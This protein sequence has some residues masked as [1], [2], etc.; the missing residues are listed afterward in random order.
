[1]S[2]STADPLSETLDALGYQGAEGLVEGSLPEAASARAFVWRELREKGELDAAYFRGSVPLVGFVR[3][4]EP[5]QVSRVQ[6]R[7]WNLSRVPLLIATTADQVGAYSCFVP[8]SPA[9]DAADARLGLARTTD[10]VSTALAEFSRFNVETG[11]LTA[12][13]PSKFLRRNRVDQRLLENLRLLREELGASHAKQ[14][15]IDTMIGRA[16]FIR[17]F[18][19]RGILSP[20]HLLE[21]TPF[22]TFIEVLRDGTEAAY[23]LF[24]ALADRFDGDVFAHSSD[25]KKL[26]SKKDLGILADFFSG[27]DMPTRQQALWPYDF[28]IIPPELISSIYEQLL[29]EDQVKD[30]AYYTPRHVV[31][32]ILDEVLPWEATNSQPRI[33]DPACG[34][35][36]FLT[37]AYRR[38]NFRNS[39]KG[40]PRFSDLVETL[41]TCIHGID[42]NPAAINVAAFG[43]YLALF[44]ELDPPSAWREAKLPKLIGR[45]LLV[46]DFFEP[47]ALDKTDF[48]VVVGNPPWQ[49]HLSPLAEEFITY[50]NV[51]LADKQIALAFLWKASRVVHDDGVLGLLL[52]AKQLLHNKAPRAIEVRRAIFESLHVDTVIDLSSLRRQT[53]TA[54][55]APAAVLVARRTNQGPHDVLHVV[56]RSSPLQLAVDGFVVSQDDIHRVPSELAVNYPDVWKIYLW[57][58]HHDLQIITRL[59]S[60]YRTLADIAKERGWIHS[61]GFEPTGPSRNDATH[62][63]GMPFIATEAVLPF[64]ITSI[65]EVVE[66]AI[67]HRPRNPL[68]FKGPH[69]LIRRGLYLGKPAAALVKQDAAFN[70]GVFGIAAPKKD[71]NYLRLLTAYINSSLGSYYQFMTSGSWG[72]ERDF[73]E[74]NEH[75]ALPFAELSD[76]Q[77]GPILDLLSIIEKRGLSQ[78]LQRKLDL[79]IYRAYGLTE[80]EIA[81]INDR[82]ATSLDQFQKRAKSVAFLPPPRAALMAY[83]RELQKRLTNALTSLKV[84]VE[85]TPGTWA[86]A[87]ASVRLTD[88]SADVSRITIESQPDV[89]EALLRQVNADVQNWPSPVTIVQPS[90]VVMAG[91]Q[92]HLVKPNEL[93]YWTVSAAEADSGDI[94]GAIAVQQPAAS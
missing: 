31:D 10:E 74:E 6:R 63:V 45:N 55:I 4:T 7:L 27:T 40:K 91:D 50:Q 39:F 20:D 66:Q 89:I 8:P 23:D 41:T 24:D 92:I 22:E 75:L 47:H 25:E 32:L 34:S 26:I 19:D 85:L 88:P 28:S 83:R 67:M 94:L 81:L 86:Y 72:V 3:A 5:E 37:E 18:E 29:E 43:L 56:P 59:R 87:V 42:R 15:A 70:N 48:D 65:D 9:G 71:I 90:A 38:L 53:F 69:V 78:D 12:A 54:A 17:Y 52:P 14:R 46:A 1:M 62:L 11:K 82:L 49:S 79:A 44:E 13:H 2:R 84:E 76:V 61:R 64:E 68:L 80:Q 36:I 51:P 93:R 77:A 58:D 21:L 16:M 33:L 30:A 60:R 57:G 35:G 73:I